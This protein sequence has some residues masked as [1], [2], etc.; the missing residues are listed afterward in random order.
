MSQSLK[1]SMDDVGI[2]FGKNLHLEVASTKERYTVRVVGCLPNNTLIVS[3]PMIDGK[4]VLLR[5]TTIINARFMMGTRVCAFV[6]KVIKMC[7][8][9]GIYFHISYPKEVESSVIREKVRLETNLI[10]IVKPLSHKK[11]IEKA[12]SGILVDLSLGGAKL[13]SKNDFGYENNFL[14]LVVKLV[15][16][17]FDQVMN[18]RCQIK[19]QE[20]KAFKEIEDTLQYNTSIS[21]I[22]TD[23]LYV[24]NLKFEGL[25]KNKL[26]LL[27]AYI[28]ENGSSPN[29]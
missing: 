25:S 23:Y 13:I 8:D 17:G 16:A 28:L 29:G 27:S 5:D 7:R 6:S 12:D 20:I 24:Y 10:S 2:P 1:V 21:K 18:M 22:K 14:D 15:V 19:M 3:A 26:I 11:S 9:P 4:S